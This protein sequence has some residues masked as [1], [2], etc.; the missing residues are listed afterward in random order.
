[1]LFCSELLHPI[2]QHG[3]F[4]HSVRCRKMPLRIE[5]SDGTAAQAGRY[6]GVCPVGP[7]VTLG[8]P[9]TAYWEERKHKKDV[10]FLLCAPSSAHA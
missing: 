2:C 3:A 7:D 5:F 9:H 10:D 4:Q 8:A 6:L 1:M